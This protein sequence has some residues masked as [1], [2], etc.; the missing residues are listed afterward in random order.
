MKCYHEM[1]GQARPCTPS[2]PCSAQASD[3]EG[4]ESCSTASGQR[5]SSRRSPKKRHWWEFWKQNR[6]EPEM[7]LLGG[8]TS[9]VEEPSPGP[10]MA[11]AG[12][13]GIDNPGSS[14]HPRRPRVQHTTEVSIGD[15][16][17]PHYGNLKKPY[18]FPR[19]GTGKVRFAWFPSLS[20]FQFPEQEAL[21]SMALQE[22]KGKHKFWRFGQSVKGVEYQ[23][24]FR[25]RMLVF[26]C[27]AYFRDLSRRDVY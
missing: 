22:I 25:K 21:R 17:S 19:L 1:V 9:P 14:T 11:F 18:E 6:P 24:A 16:S 4:D 13:D 23:L 5:S 20:S 27:A 8:N 12:S 7:T 26:A 2:S 15:I 3:S 10:S